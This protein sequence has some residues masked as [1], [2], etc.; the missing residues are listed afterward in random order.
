M[1]KINHFI[2]FLIIGIFVIFTLSACTQITQENYNKIQVGMDMSQVNL[3]LGPPTTS[4]SVNFFGATA[5]TSVWKN[6]N[7]EITILFIND[8]VEI[9]GLKQGPNKNVIQGP[10]LNLNLTNS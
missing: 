2:N 7:T 9:K 8:K 4:N 3:M 10:N 1:N 5:T 6:Q